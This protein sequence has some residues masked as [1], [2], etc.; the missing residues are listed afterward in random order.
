MWPKLRRG[1]PLLLGVVLLCRSIREPEPPKLFSMVPAPI[2]LT[3]MHQ[4]RAVYPYSIIAGGVRSPEELRTAISEDPV[5]T[6]HYTGIQ[7]SQMRVVKLVS[8]ETAYVS[9]RVHDR[10]FWTA[11]RIPLHKDELLLTDGTH[12]VRSRCGNQVSNTPREPARAAPAMDHPET[13]APREG[14]PS[15][16][17]TTSAPASATP[18]EGVPE[19]IVRQGESDR[20]AARP[21]AAVASGSA[22]TSPPFLPNPLF[23]ILPISATSSG[24]STASSVQVIPPPTVSLAPTT[25]QG[26]IFPSFAS[27]SIPNGT[28]AYNSVV[29]PA[30]LFTFLPGPICPFC[31]TQA[32]TLALSRQPGPTQ[33]VYLPPTL[34]GARRLPQ[35]RRKQK[36]CL[37]KPHL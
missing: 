20:A 35:A 34:F 18:S 27:L 32:G 7:A 22:V 9:F 5:V 15:P 33:V 28:S 23:G 19:S 13:D 10:V 4:P 30:T 21:G 14:F 37:R 17:L 25:I 8:N 36:W 1:G 12:T 29:S 6:I 11:R 24:A 26:Y 3:S 31:T 16:S 2:M